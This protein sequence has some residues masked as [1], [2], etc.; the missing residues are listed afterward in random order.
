MVLK[1][2]EKNGE[3]PF[4]FVIVFLSNEIILQMEKHLHKVFGI[5]IPKEGGEHM[6]DLK[7]EDPAFAVKE[8]IDN[9]FARRLELQEKLNSLGITRRRLTELFEYKYGMSPE[10]Y[11]A[12]IRLER[13][14]ELLN[15]G[16]RITDVAFEVGMESSAWENC[17]RRIQT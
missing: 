8:I 14:K 12:Q 4:F 16:L 9:S 13:S 15:A 7:R 2:D 6:D 17:S 10:Q 3:T 1:E 5:L 11:A